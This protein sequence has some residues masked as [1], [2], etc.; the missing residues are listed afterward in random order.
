MSDLYIKLPATMALW[1]QIKTKQRGR[2]TVKKTWHVFAGHD[3]KA[4]TETDESICLFSISLVVCPLRF[5]LIY[6][7]DQFTV[8]NA[9]HDAMHEITSLP[10]FFFCPKCSFRVDG[11]MPR[12]YYTPMSLKSAF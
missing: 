11:V 3:P 7:L 10:A 12:T 9:L 4:N 2:K 1:Q 5:F 6:S 8:G